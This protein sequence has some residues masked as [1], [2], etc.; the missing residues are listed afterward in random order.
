MSRRLPRVT[1]EEIVSA[2]KRAGFEV[3]RIRGSHHY[4]KRPSGGPIVTIPVH[5]GDTIGPRLLGYILEQAGLSPEELLA[6][7]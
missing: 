6:L 7:L 1:G 5:A 3:E 4:L 2:L